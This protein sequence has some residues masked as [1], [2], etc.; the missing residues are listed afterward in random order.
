MAFRGIYRKTPSKPC[1]FLFPKL[2]KICILYNF[3]DVKNKTKKGD[4]MTSLGF[5]TVIVSNRMYDSD[6]ISALFD[7]LSKHDIRNFIFISDFDLATN[8]FAIETEKIKKFE[9]MLSNLAPRGIHTKVVYNLLFSKGVVY[10]QSFRRL[11]ALKKHSSVFIEPPVMTED[12]YADI[13]Q[14]INYM[15]YRKKCKPLLTRFDVSLELSD[16]K[17]CEHFMNCPSFCFGFDANYI[18]SLDKYSLI[19]NIVKNKTLFI[20]MIAKDISAYEDLSFY[21]ENLKAKLGKNDYY[22]FCTCINKCA[23]FFGF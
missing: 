1:I 15:L 9:A 13:A 20:P 23:S 10:N 22:K 5:D 6:S 11:Y 16:N 7:T 14:D 19:S 3:I 12:I 18:F 17:V 8:S 21:A 2:Y 4:V